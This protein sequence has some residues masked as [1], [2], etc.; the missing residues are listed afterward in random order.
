[1]YYYI[2][3]PTKWFTA[4]PLGSFYASIHNWKIKFEKKLEALFSIL[5]IFSWKWVHLRKLRNI[6]LI[7]ATLFIT[8]GESRSQEERLSETY[9][10]WWVPYA[11]SSL[12]GDT[13]GISNY[14]NTLDNFKWGIFPNSTQTFNI[15]FPNFHI[16]QNFKG[17]YVL[18]IIK[19]I[20][21]FKI[22]FM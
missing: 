6:C 12:S 22:L 8:S 15:G 5:Y 19:G 1:M 7:F 4:L 14:I 2:Y 20:E 10:E 3:L 17:T 18:F 16:F 13:T 11:A 9:L 21:L